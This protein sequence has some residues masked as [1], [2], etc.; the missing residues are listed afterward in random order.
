MTDEVKYPVFDAADH[1]TNTDE[2]VSLLEAALEEAADDPGALPAALGII[3]R[4]GNMSELARRVDMSRDGLY[5]ALSADGNPT[6]S[7]IL[8]VTKALNLRVEI[9]PESRSA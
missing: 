7:T 4:S 9:H 3:A 1:I 8:Q 5:R 6:W 2:A